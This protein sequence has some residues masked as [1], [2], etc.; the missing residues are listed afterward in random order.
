M[1]ASPGPAEPL[2][3]APQASLRF[4]HSHSASAPNAPPMA[5]PRSTAETLPPAGPPSQPTTASAGGATAHSSPFVGFQLKASPN[6]SQATA[7]QSLTRRPG[8][9]RGNAQAPQ[10]G[11]GEG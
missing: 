9:R 4:W 11:C 8:R 5:S 1:Q 6:V 3:S 2:G 7:A 10:S